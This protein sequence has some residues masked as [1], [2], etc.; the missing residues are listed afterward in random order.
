MECDDT[1]CLFQMTSKIIS[2]SLFAKQGQLAPALLKRLL[3]GGTA[4]IRPLLEEEHSLEK[5]EPVATVVVEYNPGLGKIVG[6]RWLVTGNLPLEVRVNAFKLWSNVKSKT[7]FL[8]FSLPELSNFKFPNKGDHRNV[9]YWLSSDIITELVEVR[10]RDDNSG[11]DSA[12]LAVIQECVPNISDGFSLRLCLVPLEPVNKMGLFIVITPCMTEVLKTKCEAMKR[13]MDGPQVPQIGIPM[14]TGAMMHT[15]GYA[16]MERPTHGVGLGHLP[17]LEGYC[18]EDEER[19]LPS[20]EELRAEVAGLHRL[21]TMLRRVQ[22][23]NNKLETDWPESAI[24]PPAWWPEY[25]AVQDHDSGGNNFVLTQHNR[26]TSRPSFPCVSIPKYSSKGGFTKDT[27]KQLGVLD[28]SMC[29]RLANKSNGSLAAGTWRK[30]G[31]ASNHIIRASKE[32]NMN[33]SFPFS[34]SM[35]LNFIGYLIK[36]NIQA[37]TILSYMSGVRQA[38]IVRGVLPQH[39]RSDIISSI[40]KGHGNTGRVEMPKQQRLPVNIADLRVFK[41]NL[42]KLQ[43]PWQDKVLFWAACTWCFAGSFRIH[44]I[45]STHERTMDRSMTLTHGDVRLTKVTHGGR[46]TEVLMVRLK[47]PKEGR[48]RPV[49]VELFANNTFWCPVKAYK[50]LLKTWGC[51]PRLSDP[52]SLRNDGSL[53]TGRNFNALLKVVSSRRAVERGGVFLSHSFRSGIPSLMAAA[54]YPDSEIMRQGRWRSSAFL[55]YCKM[56]RSARLQDQLELANRIS[57]LYLHTS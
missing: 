36:R 45:L 22:K 2:S 48:G 30:Y 39:L 21:V 53:L 54:G 25:T 43:I 1:M 29:L 16:P 35:T 40:L 20:S 7:S 51:K 41:D 32:L 46:V 26:K 12:D 37:E 24:N 13:Q 38:H 44:E 11:V 15:I 34:M 31:T 50:N 17:V 18:G 47:N 14:K 6:S 23:M 4:D 28:E 42:A 55:L 56:G 9:S 8:E 27:F 10:V 3:V 33:F 19:H 5:G 57:S 49:T 52:W